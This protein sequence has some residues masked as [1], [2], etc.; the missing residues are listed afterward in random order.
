MLIA[1]DHPLSKG[2]NSSILLIFVLRPPSQPGHGTKFLTT[3]SGLHS[4]R[5]GLLDFNILSGVLRYYGGCFY[6]KGFSL[7][8]SLVGVMSFGIRLGADS[9][10]TT[11][12]IHFCLWSGSFYCEFSFLCLSIGVRLL[13]FLVLFFFVFHVVLSG[14]VFSIHFVC[15]VYCVLGLGF[16]GRSFI[17]GIVFC[18][19]LV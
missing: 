9:T 12:G 4:D 6:S 11:W 5:F 2:L 15:I 19:F 18:R 13:E 7:L 8:L 3:I 1:T 10:C 16:F 14:L 17:L